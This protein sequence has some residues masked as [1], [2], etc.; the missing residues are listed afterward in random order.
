M[1]KSKETQ[2]DKRLIK[3]ELLTNFFYLLIICIIIHIKANENS[4]PV[5]N[6]ITLKINNSGNISVYY[7]RE[8]RTSYFIC[9]WDAHIPDMVEINGIIQ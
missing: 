1:T 3:K 6:N 9:T 8:T 5:Y 7:S 4:E 2:N